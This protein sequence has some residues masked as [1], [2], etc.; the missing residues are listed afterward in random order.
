M[1]R[2]IRLYCAFARISLLGEM[3]FRANYLIKTFVEV[4]W[5]CLMAFFYDR[6][7]EF[8][9]AVAGWSSPGAASA[10]LFQGQRD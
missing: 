4:A 6:L 7:F 1:M 10:I 8:T 9:A 5:L 3:S 2:Y